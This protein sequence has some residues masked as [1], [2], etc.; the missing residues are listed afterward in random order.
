MRDKNVLST[1]L[2][3]CTWVVETFAWSFTCVS[4]YS[5]IKLSQTLV[6]IQDVESAIVIFSPEEKKGLSF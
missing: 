3:L 2:G 1:L 5:P 6:P 4:F